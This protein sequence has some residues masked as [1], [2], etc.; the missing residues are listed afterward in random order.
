[1]IFF[2]FQ[3]LYCIF[4]HS[5]GAAFVVVICRVN[6]IEIQLGFDSFVYKKSI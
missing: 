4:S 3:F 2:E 1:M 5:F 6:G